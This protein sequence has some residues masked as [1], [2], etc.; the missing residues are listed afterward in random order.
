MSDNW[1]W[2]HAILTSYGAWLP[3]DDRGFRTRHHRQHVEGDYKNPPPPGEYG[4]LQRYGREVLTQP[5]VVFPPDLR[6]VIGNAV[7]E[8]LQG[9]GALPICVA[10]AG[11]HVH[12]LAKMPFGEWLQWQGLAKRHVYFVL[13]DHGWSGKVW[14]KRRKIVVIRNR[15]QQLSTYRYILRHAEEG[16][17]TWSIMSG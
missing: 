3:G 15:Q 6:P 7:R 16:A 12:L 10:V 4:G 13:R 17:W 14:G 1:Y 8:R 11:R 5:P 9:L 2:Y